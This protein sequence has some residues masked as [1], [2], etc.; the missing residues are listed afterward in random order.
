MFTERTSVGGFQTYAG[1]VLLA[2]EA[3]RYWRVHDHRIR[4]RWLTGLRN[5]KALRP[6]CFAKR[7][8]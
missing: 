7:A 3:R 8:S 6:W 4:R 2:A 5:P 1:N